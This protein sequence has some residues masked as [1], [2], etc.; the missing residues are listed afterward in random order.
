MSNVPKRRRRIPKPFNLFPA[1]RGRP[2]EL[3]MAMRAWQM[4]RKGYPLYLVG[5]GVWAIRE[6]ERETEEAYRAGDFQRVKD[7]TQ[8]AFREALKRYPYN[9]STKTGP[10]KVLEVLAKRYFVQAEKRLKDS[11]DPDR[12][13]YFALWTE[14]HI[15]DMRAER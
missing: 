6:T 11:S 9:D 10:R 4:R 2:P 5:A 14:R 1:P 15:K 7:L 13:A 12:D 3:A 8:R